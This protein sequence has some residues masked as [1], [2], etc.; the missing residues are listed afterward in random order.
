M[1]SFTCVQLRFSFRIQ[2]ISLG[3]HLVDESLGPMLLMEV[4][5]TIL[6]RRSFPKPAT[7]ESIEPG[8]RDS[9][10]PATNMAIVFM[11]VLG[12]PLIAH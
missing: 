8:Y 2:V 9:P 11:K 1:P 12:F 3:T 6:G 10:D 5:P 7:L 4:M